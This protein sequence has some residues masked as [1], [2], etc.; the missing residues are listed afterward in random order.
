MLAVTLAPASGKALAGYVLSGPRPEVLEPL[1][2][3]R[4]KEH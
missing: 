2:L 1:R 3:R 4:F